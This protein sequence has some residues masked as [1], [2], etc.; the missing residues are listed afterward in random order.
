V[1]LRDGA[2]RDRGTD[3]EIGPLDVSQNREGP[4]PT[5]TG[6]A[7]PAMLCIVSVWEEGGVFAALLPSP[8]T[9]LHSKR[10]P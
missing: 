10:A 1:V 9:L 2:P 7:E 8:A 5:L 3:P 6:E 4:G